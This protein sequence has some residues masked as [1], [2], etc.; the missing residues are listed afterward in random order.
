M[1]QLIMNWTRGN[2]ESLF[3][4]ELPEG[5]SLRKFDQSETDI[6]AWLDIV[7]HGLTDGRG[8]RALF[9]DLMEQHSGYDPDGVFFI[10]QNGRPCATFSVF[11]DLATLHG[12]LHMVCVSPSVRGRGI[13]T[14]LARLAVNEFRNRGMK[15]AHL[16]T[17]DFRIPAII[18]YLEAGF[19]PQY[20][21]SDDYPARWEAVRRQIKK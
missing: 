2:D 12:Y 21:G 15:T 14:A 3:E 13:G 5:F 16:T 8:S 20:E 18:T 1:E 6:N 4:V 11:C 7:Q 10:E 9:R 17:D 19:V